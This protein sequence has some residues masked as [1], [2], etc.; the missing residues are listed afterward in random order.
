MDA[1]KWFDRPFDFS[2]HQNDYA[3]VY[4]RLRRA[5]SRFQEITANLPDEIANYKPRGTWSVKEH[6]GH[7]PVLEPLWRTRIEDIQRAAGQ[8]S[9][10]DLENRGTTEAGFN[11]HSLAD[12]L[13]ALAEERSRTLA[14]L[15]KVSE[16]EHA[17]TSLHARLQFPMRIID[18]A[19][20]MAEHD[21][22]H[23][24]RIRQIVD[25]FG[26][27]SV[28]PVV[29]TRMLESY[30]RQNLMSLYGAEVSRIDEGSFEIT[31]PARESLLR[32][33]GIF[34]GGVMAALADTSAG[35]A[36]ATLQQED[37][38]FLTVEFKINFLNP[39]KGD[40][41]VAKARSVKNGKTLCVSQAD[42]YA[43]ANGNETLA[44]TSIVTL[45][46]SKR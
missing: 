39:A 6:T 4:E 11:N 40:K 36:A 14:L 21:E 37:T 20:F 9:P 32:T 7:I 41:L 28:P 18:L 27:G 31:L 12:L 23:L 43:V 8:L 25:L 33:S 5:P 42:I 2:L 45:I 19:Y 3:S 46:K 17:R 10:A 29:V 22:H 26:N 44:A 38:Y 15:D 30:W 24:E 35:Y 16:E 34:N 1:K 13:N